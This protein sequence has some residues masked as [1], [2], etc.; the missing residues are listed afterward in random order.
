MPRIISLGIV[1]FLLATGISAEPAK[2]GEL[3]NG[4]SLAGWRDKTGDWAAVGEVAVNPADPKLFAAKPGEGVL[5]NGASGKSVNLISVEEFGDVE[6]HIEFCIP[7][8]S[9]SGV[10]FQGRYEIQ[11]LDSYGKTELKYGDCGGVYHNNKGFEGHAPT[12]NA[13]KAPGDWQTF[14]VVFQAPRFDAAGKKTANAKFVKVTHNGKVI[15]ENIEVNAPTIAATFSDE[16]PAGPFMF[17][18]DHGPVAYR[19]LRIKRL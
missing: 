10:Y 15:H 16:K 14:D 6:A 13:C 4:K 1:L 2:V 12:V 11:V 3:F 5:Y 7:K 19:N 9:N 8:D 18:G 17:Q